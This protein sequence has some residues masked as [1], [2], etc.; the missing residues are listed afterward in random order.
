[1]SALPKTP[2]TDVPAWVREI[3][4]QLVGA[5]GRNPERAT[6]REL[7][8][9]LALTTRRRVLE[10]LVATE[11]RQG[12]AK[13]VG[14]LSMEF[15][16]GRSLENSLSNLGLHDVARR[17]T[18]ELGVDLD[19]LSELEPDAALGN[20]GLGRLAACFLDSLASLDL[21]A[22]GYGLRYQFGLFRQE[23]VGR[24]QREHPDAWDAEG[25]PWLVERPE[26]A[27]LVPAYGQVV[28][29]M[30]PDGQSYPMWLDWKLVVG[31]PYDMP[32]VGYGGRTVNPLRLFAARAPS[33]IDMA[34]F[35]SGD[36]VRAVEQNIA[37]ETLSKILY[38]ADDVPAGRELRLLQEYFLVAC[39]VRDVFRRIEREGGSP[40]Q[41]P[42]RFAL[43]LNDTHPSLAIAE[44]MRMLL[45]EVRMPWERAWEL[46]VATIGYTNHTL[47][48]EALERWPVPL[49]EK[50][51]PRHLQIIYDINQRFLADVQQRWPG[52]LTRVQ[53]MSLVEES[54][55]K[56]VRMAH[57]CVVGS[58][59]I[60][61][62]AAIHSELVRTR[63]LPEFAE[64]WPERFGNRTNGV[65]PRR[66]ILQA[67]PSLAALLD[68]RIGKRWVTDL[69]L[70]AGLADHAGDPDLQAEVLAI[71][72][73][74]KERLAK[75]VLSATGMAIDPGSF[76]D[77]QIKRI[78]EYK[79]Q[80][81]NLL[82]VA[83]LYLRIVEDGAELAQPRTVLISG[84]AAPSYRV[85]KQV[86]HLANAMSA[87]IDRDPRARDQLRLV[88]VP[89]Y[90]V[91]LAER[92]VPAAE[93]SQQ[94]STAGTEASGTGNMKLA[95]NG[96]ITLGTL[97]GANIEI[98][99]AVGPDGVFVFGLTVPEVEAHRR[100][101][102]Y[103]PRATVDADPR[104]R[105][106]LDAIAGGPF[107]TGPRESFADLVARLLH[108][109]PYF[110]LADFAGCVEANERAAQARRDEAGWAR[111]MILNIAH[112]GRFSSDRTIREYA[113]DTWDL[114]PVNGGT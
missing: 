94:I 111:R 86:I 82:H 54:N 55:P 110:V 49:L 60:N 85:A 62:V 16:M 99:D 51:L 70:T 53:R 101:G 66:W 80:L 83:H 57:L 6:P 17:A 109:D 33:E 108:H 65:T 38:P 42:A 46:T 36:Y 69:E 106:V 23:I 10:R 40:E 75:V 112:M 113:T 19:A 22:I 76:H 92:I 114:K 15:L 105:R 52:D 91:S 89:D 77:V 104:L 14:Y 37:V 59:A 44:V 29:A 67:N 27:C 78:H 20:G 64:L 26:E 48:P 18:A 47:M 68:R 61:G 97:D 96:A 1:V 84:K 9:A 79:R 24:E 72:R 107:S 45:D 21:P 41:L 87:V 50:V 35:N 98:A 95:M 63:L 13:R 93:L 12:G 74:N 31:V 2:A 32:V 11:A 8:R 25:S 58:H 90:R 3:H 39:A 100:D 30:G 43:Q 4:D 73:A 28:E 88:F 5:L 71:K 7:A 102:T 103:D 56:Q 81:L 34:T